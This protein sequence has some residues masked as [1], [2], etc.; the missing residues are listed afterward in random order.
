VLSC[1]GNH[2]SKWYKSVAGSNGVA[3]ISKNQR[4]DQMR[5]AIDAIATEASRFVHHI[6]PNSPSAAEGLKSENAPVSDNSIADWNST[7]QNTR[8][9]FMDIFKRDIAELGWENR[10]FAVEHSHRE[11]AIKVVET[12]TGNCAEKSFLAGIVLNAT[13]ISGLKLRGFSEKEIA[14]A[15]IKLTI[16]ELG[17]PENKSNEHTVCILSYDIGGERSIYVDSWAGGALVDQNDADEFYAANIVNLNRPL[18]QTKV[19]K[20]KTEVI[21]DDVCMT[22]VMQYVANVYEI[23]LD[24]LHPFEKYI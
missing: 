10:Y 13:L 3:E 7:I 5:S 16:V 21:N 9:H 19:H 15:N 18:I 20:D 17:E 4:S 24:S 2:A 8:G 11:Y 23:N 12:K 6:V 22:K 14:K 1:I